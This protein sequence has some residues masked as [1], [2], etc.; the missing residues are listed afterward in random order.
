MASM[1]LKRIKIMLG[2]IT[3]IVISAAALLFPSIMAF[4]TSYK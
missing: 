2:G 1:K 4:V 3:V